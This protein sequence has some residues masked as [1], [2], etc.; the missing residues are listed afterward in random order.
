M[1]RTMEESRIKSAPW[2]HRLR[3]LP[4]KHHPHGLRKLGAGETQ[5]F[6]FHAI[7]G[8]RILAALTGPVS[9]FSPLERAR[10]LVATPLVAFSR[11]YCIEPSF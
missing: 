4:Q 7:A 10:K 9:F 11:V 3:A 5:H 1:P 2:N 8:D 6:S